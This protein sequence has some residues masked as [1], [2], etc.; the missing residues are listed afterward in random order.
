MS[1][2]L[3]GAVTLD[4]AGLPDVDVQALGDSVLGWA[5]RRVR[6]PDTYGGQAAAGDPIAA[7]QDS[8]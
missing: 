3:I 5:V 1:D 6:A 4:A 8:M 2:D 7:F